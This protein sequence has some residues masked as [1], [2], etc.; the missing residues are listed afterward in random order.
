MVLQRIDSV[1][2]IG[3]GLSGVVAASRLRRAGLSVH[4]LEKSRG[5][6]GRMAS[7]RAGDLAFDHGAQYFTA[8]SEAFA[9]EVAGWVAAGLA[10]PW[11]G[12]RFVGT[13]AMN[14][15]VKALAADLPLTIG[16]TATGIDGAPGRWF[17]EGAEGARVGPVDAVLVSAPS[18][19]TAAL[20]ARVAPSLARSAERAVYA[21][22]L[23]LMLAYEPDA[24]PAG[25]APE[26]PDH[27]AVAWISEENAK[28]GRGPSGLRRIVAHATPDF[29]RAHL[30][31]P[32]ERIAAL[33]LDEVAPLIGARAAPAHVAAHRWRYALVETPL[34]TPCLWDPALALGACGDWC[35]AGRI[36]A[37]HTSGAALADRV[38]AERSPR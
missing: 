15:P 19:Q 26:R 18:P 9:A 3:A 8:R 36:E 10:V 27:P 2:V 16:F 37:A 30:E 14:A 13:P 21:P 35:L 38:L 25:P 5:A 33:L 31:E 22:C 6:G 4:I 1:A 7:R 23:A 11:G 29:S 32:P 17:V 34:G 28:P 12:D 20:L 24:L